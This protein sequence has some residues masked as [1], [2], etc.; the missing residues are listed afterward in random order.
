MILM[1]LSH[2]CN[3][4]F[5]SLRREAGLAPG[6]AGDGGEAQGEAVQM[7]WGSSPLPPLPI[8]PLDLV[9]APE[10]EGG[11]S[12]EQATGIAGAAFSTKQM[13][14]MKLLGGLF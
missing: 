9:S 6:L 1:C 5:P 7:A 4:S 3:N 10:T 8:A 11:S 2:A 12:R 13:D 14:V